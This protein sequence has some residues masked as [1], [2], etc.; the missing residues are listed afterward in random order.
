[1]IEFISETGPILV[2]DDYSSLLSTLENV[3]LHGGDDCP[4]NTLSALVVGLENALPNSFVLVFTDASAN[5][6]RFES[7]VVELIQRKQATVC[8]LPESILKQRKITRYCI[9]IFQMSILLTG[10]CDNKQNE[11]Y[12]VY[13]RLTEI[14]NGQVYNIRSDSIGHMIDDFIKKLDNHH[15]LLTSF[16]APEADSSRWEFSV[17]ESVDT[18]ELIISG[19]K[20]KVWIYSPDGKMIKYET[21]TVSLTHVKSY[22][23]NSPHNGTWQIDVES[24]SAHSVRITANSKLSFSYG[25]SVQ[26]PTSMLDTH[27]FP[28][29]GK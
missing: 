12:K 28:L 17:D 25:F 10:Y 29:K 11:K 18:L 20:P 24:K 8:N 26:S 9:Y 4:E 14:S 3:Q 2:T 27:L 21:E 16:Y 23:V 7:E 13:E 15:V 19:E 1:M 6:F 5:D 22:I